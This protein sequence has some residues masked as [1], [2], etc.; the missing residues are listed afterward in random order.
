MLKAWYMQVNEPI[1][2]QGGEHSAQV[3]HLP[4]ISQQCAM[5]SFMWANL[6]KE[7]DVVAVSTRAVFIYTS[8]VCDMFYYDLIFF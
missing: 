6:L 8:A 5:Y 4:A 3:G 7:V 1:T 2:G